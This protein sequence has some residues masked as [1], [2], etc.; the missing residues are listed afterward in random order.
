MMGGGV[1]IKICSKAVRS[2]LH[3]WW[4]WWWWWWWQWWRTLS[5]IDAQKPIYGIKCLWEFGCTPGGWYWWWWCWWWGG[6][7][8]GGWGWFK[9]MWTC[10]IVPC[11]SI[12]GLL[13][14]RLIVG[15]FNADAEHH[16]EWNLPQHLLLCAWNCLLWM[17]LTLY[18]KTHLQDKKANT[19]CIQK[20]YWS[21]A[22]RSFGHDS[23]LESC[24]R[25]V[26]A[27]NLLKCKQSYVD[28][29]WKT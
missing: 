25:K 17:H 29:Y 7:G 9:V 11:L 4:S 21:Q 20:I 24:K 15:R 13:Q 16:G 5:H 3:F 8:G 27:A 10:E 6:G 12:S 2:H 1:L 18:E 22:F 14:K 28:Q 19:A 23:R 26:V